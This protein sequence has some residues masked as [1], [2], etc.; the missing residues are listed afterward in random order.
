VRAILAIVTVVSFTAPVLAVER[1]IIADTPVIVTLPD[2]FSAL[3]DGH[4]LATP[5]G[6]AVVV[7]TQ[8]SDSLFRSIKQTGTSDFPAIGGLPVGSIVETP[9]IAGRNYYLASGPLAV[10]GRPSHVWIAVTGPSP[11]VNLEFVQADSAQAP[12]FS[13]DAVLS[14]LRT[15]QLGPRVT[16]EQHARYLGF[17]ITPKAPFVGSGLQTGRD[18]V[19][20]VSPPRAG[21][22]IL[23]ISAQS[24]DP[25]LATLG[26]V[27]D[28]DL[29]SRPLASMTATDEQP[30]ITNGQAGLRRAGTGTLSDGS[31]VA[32]V[33]HVVFIDGRSFALSAVGAPD[34]LSSLMPTIDEIVASFTVLPSSPS[35]SSQ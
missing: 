18:A 28:R 19:L 6:S 16:F 3:P 9:V 26:A 30:W 17:T 5:D 34:Q 11:T 4:I 24:V 15:V 25:N 23:W 29:K 33:Q 10:A 8:L 14:I 31:P 32:F 27:A 2:G 35:E 21:A 20:G 1:H 7:V 13:R 12:V 22:P